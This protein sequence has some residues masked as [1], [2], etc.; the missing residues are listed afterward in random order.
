MMLRKGLS[1]Y[2]VAEA[3]TRGAAGS[4]E[5]VR[6]DTHETL[7]G[8]RHDLAKIRGYI[9]NTGQGPEVAYDT[10]SFEGK[11]PTQQGCRIRGLITVLSFLDG[12]NNHRYIW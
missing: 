3:A 10:S 11:G 12:K 7:S 1:R 6:L 8:I 5:D 2:H 4:N 9:I